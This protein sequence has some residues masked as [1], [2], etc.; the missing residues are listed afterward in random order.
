MME[1]HIMKIDEIRC[2]AIKWT[3]D[4]DNSDFTHHNILN[5]NKNRAD[6]I[7]IHTSPNSGD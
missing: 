5:C 2:S 3:W 4:C 6:I 7:R 1:A